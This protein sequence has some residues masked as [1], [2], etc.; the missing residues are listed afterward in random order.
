MVLVPMVSRIEQ[1]FK[2]FKGLQSNADRRKF[3]FGLKSNIDFLM[4]L[5]IRIK[6]SSYR[7]LPF[8]IV[9]NIC[10]TDPF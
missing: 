5:D 2:V 3:R 6:I 1:S 7:I 4:Q 10:L 9:Q 8:I